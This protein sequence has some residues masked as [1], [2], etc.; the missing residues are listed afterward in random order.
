M[1]TREEAVRRASAAI[2]HQGRAVSARDYEE[3]AM[4]ASRDIRMVKCFAGYD[5]RALPLSGAVTLV[6]LQKQFRQGQVQ[7][8]ALKETLFEYM[9][10]RIGTVLSDS[11]RFFIVQPDFIEIRLRIEL[12]VE[13]FGRASQI[14][15]EVLQRL[16]QFLSPGSQKSEA[17]WK[18]GQFPN[19]MQ[20]KNA[21]G[22]IH[23]ITCIHNIMMSAY[24]AG[25]GEKSEVDIEAVRSGRYVL[26]VNGEHD[27]I[28]L[29]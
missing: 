10:N 9:K 21:L 29:T 23:G 4:C 26:P 14:K 16:E 20:I 12:S 17:G 3:L 15:N 8:M 22:S 5:D 2:R 19:V 1:E 28:I 13:D 7:F 27:I 6:V 11:R 24:T 18:I 25:A